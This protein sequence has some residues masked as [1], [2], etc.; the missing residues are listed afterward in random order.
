M[1]QRSKE[2]FV[3][4]LQYNHGFA[5]RDETGFTRARGADDARGGGKA[6][7]SGGGRFVEFALKLLK[8]PHAMRQAEFSRAWL[9]VVGRDADANDR[10]TVVA[11]G[12]FRG[13]VE[14]AN[15]TRVGDL[16]SPQL[17]APS[18]STNT[19]PVVG[20]AS[21]KQ[22]ASSTSTMMPS[23]VG[24]AAGEQRERRGSA[25]RGDAASE[26]R[27]VTWPALFVVSTCA[28]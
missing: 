19:P 12:S 17:R 16:P 8:G 7:G 25:E 3:F 9:D 15:P 27:G 23:S 5:L 6:F 24:D 21:G 26:P 13:D 22:R 20:G 11:A 4:F 1:A 28:E 10:V 2:P 14:K 18:T